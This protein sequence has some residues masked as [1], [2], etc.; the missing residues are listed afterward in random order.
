MSQAKSKR[1]TV[2]AAALPLIFLAILLGVRAGGARAHST[3]RVPDSYLV[4]NRDDS[5]EGSLRQAIMDAN[6]NP[7]PDTIE[8]DKSAWGTITLT[9][10]ELLITDDLTITGPGPF[11]LTISG[12]HQSR[13]FEIGSSATVDI[14]GL[15]IS[16]GGLAGVNGGGIYNQGTLMLTNVVLSGNSVSGGMDG[17]GIFN[18]G[19]LTIT[20]STLSGNSAGRNGGGVYNFGSSSLTIINS[21]LSGNS[22]AAA[23]GGVYNEGF[24][25]IINSTLSGNFTDSTVGAGGGFYNGIGGTA[26]ISFTTI[27]NNSAHAG[28]GIYNNGATVN[29]KNSIVANNPSGG[30]CA[31][32]GATV[33][34]GVNFTTTGGC[35]FTQVPST[36][37]G[38]LN[39]GP[40]ADN[41][42]PTQTH[43]LLPGSVAIDAAPDCTP[44][45]SKTP[46]ETDQ[47]GILRPQGSACDVGS[48]EAVP[49][50]T[51]PAIFCPESFS[52][53][54]DA[55]QCAAKVDY[56]LPPVDCPCNAG[57]GGG[58]RPS[59]PKMV[60]PRGAAS[61]TPSCSPPP[62]SNFPRGT[63][64][65]T[66]SVTDINNAT[67]MCSFTITVTDQVPPALSCPASV[68]K[69]TDP[70]QC[71]AA[72]TYTV[73]ANDNC[74]GPV[75]ATCT[76]PSGSIFQKGTTTV[77]CT[78]TDS[79]K[80]VGTCMFPVTVNDTQP[81]A[82][83]CPANTSQSAGPGQCSATVTYPPP[84]VSDNC[85]N[86]GAPSCSPPS[87]STFQGG[88]TTVTCMVA[89]ASGNTASCS[90]TVTVNDTTP[91]SITCPANVTVVTTPGA[92]CATVTYPAPKA[93]DNCPLP[94]NAV[95]CSPPSGSC[96]ARGTT[97]VNCTVT[98]AG[99]N[100]ASCSF[101]VTVFDL[102][103]QDDSNPTTVVLVNTLT[104]DYRFCCNGTT[105][106]GRGKITIRGNTYTLDHTAADRRVL[107]TDDEGVHRATA[108]LQVPPG[109][110]RCTINDRDT[111]N[112][113]CQC[114]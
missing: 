20:N 34:S 97:T 106:T 52:V 1:R 18:L 67:A 99:G 102:C 27:A 66:C 38:G 74:D 39:L 57:G 42:G 109:T 105:F 2:V 35:G 81:P 22:A 15:T 28:G 30:D 85:P 100:T 64:T 51:Q 96:F 56:S 32:N 73:T 4:T 65:V 98:D 48:Y 83:T 36:G 69:S 61:C 23:G 110:P 5:G 44:L 60:S 21:T 80:N 59:S 71:Q 54:T 113:T 107:V 11:T 86:V 40:L 9:S 90:F 88:T 108:S 55:N 29:V 13:I 12:N 62:G 94:P 70:N 16:D 91:P 46:L 68:T 87:G 89:D 77:T 7:G 49:C 26:D 24:L 93:S 50:T 19:T 79:S 95:V 78:A 41:G 58:A 14:S 3:T 101:R 76:P 10:G 75:P 47:R 53:S 25:T 82:I 103:I 8:F 104:G 31:S 84:T 72:V 17:G 45:N 43:A 33:A 114:Q 111:R 6:A 92:T 37:P 63:T 112:N